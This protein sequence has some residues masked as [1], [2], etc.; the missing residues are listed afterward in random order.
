MLCVLD[1]GVSCGVLNFMRWLI[2]IITV[3]L[4]NTLLDL[5]SRVVSVQYEG[6]MV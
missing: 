3:K 6:G 1:G 4:D 5:Y 2:V